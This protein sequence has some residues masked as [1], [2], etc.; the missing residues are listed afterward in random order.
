[1]ITH[2]VINIYDN[3]KIKL[4]ESIV[5]YYDERLKNILNSDIKKDEE[6]EIKKFY[7]DFVEDV[8]KYLTDN[9]IDYLY[10]DSKYFFSDIDYWEDNI[11]NKEKEHEY[12]LYDTSNNIPH[13]L[14]CDCSRCTEIKETNK[15]IFNSI[16]ELSKNRSSVKSG[17]RSENYDTE[18]SEDHREDKNKIFNI[19]IDT[20][21][22]LLLNFLVNLASLFLILNYQN[23]N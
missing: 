16:K 23:K 3:Y 19:K 10:S 1:M 5:K 6:Y 18:Y 17:K 12:L 11:N 15:K 14:Y 2:N 8:S 13:S 4:P 9:E 7:L 21:T 20:K 22:V